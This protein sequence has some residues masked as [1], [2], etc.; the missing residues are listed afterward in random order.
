MR[1]G[2]IPRLIFGRK[3]KRFVGAAGVV[4]ASK[5]RFVFCARCIMPMMPPKT[6]AIDFDNTF[7]ADPYMWA[8]TLKVFKARGHQPLC[9]TA[10]RDTAEN[11]D[12]INA[13]FDHH[14][15][16][17]PIY[18]SSL[19]SKL[20]FMESRGIKVDIWIDDDPQS[21]VRGL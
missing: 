6:I 8:A 12:A 13:V 9:V 18:F 20:A 17:M 3:P 11:A 5:P 21:V 15:C 4:A 19:G 7:T 2:E 10:R 14:N 16:Q 1:S